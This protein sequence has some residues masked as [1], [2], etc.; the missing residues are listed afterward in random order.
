VVSQ[1]EFLLRFARRLPKEMIDE[2][3][4]LIGRL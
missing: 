2:R 1:E 4:L 3:E